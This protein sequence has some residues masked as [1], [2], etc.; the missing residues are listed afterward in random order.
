MS[1]SLAEF[2]KEKGSVE[3]AARALNVSRQSM[4]RWLAGRSKPSRVMTAWAQSQ[5]IDLSAPTRGA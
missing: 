5:G 4:D 3:Q 2:I 1:K